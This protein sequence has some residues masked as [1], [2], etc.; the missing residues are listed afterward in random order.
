M[1]KAFIG[2]MT[3]RIFF[4]LAAGTLISAALVVALAGYERNS[5]ESR[6]R[7]VHTA[8][9]IEQIILMLEA[10][11]QSSRPA[12]AQVVEKYGIKI[13]L[14]GATTLIGEFPNTALSKE[15]KRTLGTGKPLTIIEDAGNNCAVKRTAHGGL[16]N[17]PNRCLTIITSL[18]DGS[19]LRLDVARNQRAPLPFQ[20]NF[21]RNLLLFLSG[22]VLIALFVAH[23]ATK[24]LRKL[25]QAAHDLGQNIEHP[26]LSENEG[27]TEVK[28]ASIAFNSMQTSIRNH[29][30][31]RT[32]M[33]AAI[34]H[35][36]QTPLTRLRL[37]LENVSDETLRVKL[38]ADMTATLAMVKEGLD[39]ARSTNTEEPFER[40]DIDSLIE[41]ICNDATDAGA[42]VTC[43]G[44]IGKPIYAYP[45]S[46]RRC[47]TNLLDNAI[48]YGGSAQVT[49]N[50]ENTKAVISIIDNG[51]GIPNKQL[52]VVFQ[53]F[54]RIEDSRSRHSGG[55]GLGLT[56][57]RMIAEKHKG[58]IKLKNLAAPN[59]GLIATLILPISQNLTA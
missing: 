6:I 46:L 45:H 25:A 16:P 57:A 10:A 40:V 36:L 33:L 59:H 42:E 21:V 20:G 56:I 44:K 30:Q 23:M 54:K 47:I 52:E 28:E 14:T 19:P 50:Q 31:E 18:S 4:I 22:I 11:P 37:R 55:T 43:S 7:L 41:A 2:S 3:A 26:A 58:S 35:D 12:L 9:R 15:L 17:K 51:L 34:A 29:L 38:I 32:Y 5:F 53:P 8:E 27:S 1:I 48:K 24:P 39:F 49:V 13:D